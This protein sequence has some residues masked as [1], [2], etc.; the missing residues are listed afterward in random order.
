M[1]ER[2]RDLRGKQTLCL[3]IISLFQGLSAKAEVPEEAEGR[4]F[5]PGL[6][7]GEDGSHLKPGWTPLIY[8]SDIK[9]SAPV[10][11]YATRHC[12]GVEYGVVAGIQV[13]NEHAYLEENSFSHRN[14]Q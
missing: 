5:P 9:C 4:I 11:I 7:P 2:S 6:H 10:C 1:T 3:I 12:F 14:K 8:I 13:T